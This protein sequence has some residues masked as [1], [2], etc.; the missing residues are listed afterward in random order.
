[1]SSIALSTIRTTLE[2]ILSLPTSDSY[3][4][5]DQELQDLNE[6]Y[7]KSA[8]K[9]DWPQLLVK[10]GIPLRANDRKYLIPSN[11]RK[12][13]S[14]RVRNGLRTECELD[15]IKRSW[16]KYAIDRSTRELILHELPASASTA[17]TL[18]N[19]ES[20]GNAVTIELD[21]TSGLSVGDEIFIDDATNP[22]V[23]YVVSITAGASIV[24]RLASSKSAG[25]ILYRADDCIMMNY[26]MAITKLSASTDTILLPDEVDLIICH[27]AA[28]LAF[29]RLEDKTRSDTQLEKWAT[30][31]ADAWLA[32]DKNSTG[33]TAEF[34]VT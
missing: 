8:Y 34:V 32:W 14:V 21:V 30:R 27:Y 17:Y 15:D 11:F 25:T 6:G 5:S 28:H 13:H 10:R 3:V 2:L 1:M 29:D 16:G 26:Y 33:L 9:Y 31:L 22:E 18:S 19:A 23:T 4:G 24:A 7:Q 12:M 20:A